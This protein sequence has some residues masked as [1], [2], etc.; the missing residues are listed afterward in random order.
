M[1]GISS[2]SPGSIQVGEGVFRLSTA[3][4]S[5][6]F[7]KTS[8]GHLEHLHYGVRLGC[9][10]SPEA[11]AIKRTAQSGSC[12][13]YDVEDNLYCLDSIP[14]EW[15]GIGRGD[16]RH[17]PAELVMPDGTFTCDFVF[18]AYN[19]YSGALPMD[20]LPSAYGREHSI[21]EG[22]EACCGSDCETLEILL[23]DE[24]NK[25]GL[26]LFWSVYPH[27]DVITRRAVLTN[28]GGRR[29]LIRRLMSMMTD[30]P[31]RNFQII[32]FDGAWIKEAHKHKRPVSPGIHVIS[33]TTGASSNRH[34]PGFLL[35]EDT[36]AEVHG[37]VY[38][39][40]L[41]YSGNHYSAIELTGQGLVRV[42]SGI[43]PHCF[44]WTLNTGEHF[45]TPEA[46]MTYS[47]KGYNG[48]S[49]HFHD[50]VN[51]H[52][53]RGAWKNR[54]RPVLANNWEAC[55]F[56][57]NQQKLLKLAKQA[58][59]IGAELFVLDDGWFGKR[60]SDTAGLG[61][62]TVNRKKL[63]RG[64]KHF[65][66][67]I[68]RMGLMFGL[69][70]EPEMLNTDSDLFRLHPEYAVTTPGK[71]PTLGRNQLVLDLCRQEVRDYI[72]E[73]VGKVLDENNI[74]YVKWD[75]NRHISDAF[76]PVLLNQGEFLHRYILGLYDV[77]GR[78]FRPRPHILLESCSSGG[79]RFDLGMLCFSPQIWASDNTDP[80]ERL[81]IQGGLTY[82]YP[83]S[84][85]CA[86][87]TDAPHQQTLRNTAL[88]TRFNVAAFGS[89]GYELDFRWLNTVEKRE[90][91][92]Q[93][94]FYKRHRKTFQFG[95]FF[96]LP[97]LK[98]NKIH[99]QCSSPD[100]K[101]AVSGFYQTRSYAS[102]GYD[103]LP[104]TDL[105]PNSV[106]TVET[107]PQV[108][109]ISRFGGLIKHVLPLS[110]HPDGFILRLVNRLYAM[111]DCVEEYTAQGAL[112]MSGL[113]LNSP[114]LGTHYNNKTRL[115]GDFGSNLYLVTL[116]GNGTDGRKTG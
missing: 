1:S 97:A 21:A 49:R 77:L 63:P 42:Q 34:N 78:I 16:Y 68:H 54:E 106:Y 102:E 31:N 62:Y 101:E 100:G 65:S 107:R 11:L 57:F 14:L 99:W 94:D 51:N 44:E 53:V 111:E 104:L 109:H 103:C 81:D 110:L 59:N 43:N 25:V 91:K 70:F 60:D 3:N 33:S 12:I 80:G 15:S 9:D 75:M 98:D 29:L 46:V 23:E 37:S 66:R 32:S 64:M 92:S 84:T 76:S 4:S 36:A 113:R 67:L 41:I 5:L 116:T 10:Q 114:F 105:E 55:F 24:S 93:I 50:F 69:W 18:K 89:L 96:R 82:L 74:D 73:A 7:R 71:V 45:E 115:L 17:S 39:F 26:R 27:T 61:D 83:L 112:L 13:A 2:N 48:V 87:V 52:I 86:H 8:Y 90:L 30:L 56:K 19:I 58:K 88:S 95:R 40:N 79:N 47:D 85:I 35:A 22:E 6:W 72:V 28:R 108:L 20:S 38:G